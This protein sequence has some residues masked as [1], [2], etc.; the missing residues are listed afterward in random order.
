MQ[1]SYKCQHTDAFCCELLHVLVTISAHFKLPYSWT[2]SWLSYSVFEVGKYTEK[3]L[4]KVVQYWNQSFFPISVS[5]IFLEIIPQRLE[6]YSVDYPF[7]I[8]LNYFLM[9]GDS[10]FS[11]LEN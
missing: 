9:S 11:Y 6:C 3:R 4:E 7:F 2:P 1:K 8:F 5:E 10:Y